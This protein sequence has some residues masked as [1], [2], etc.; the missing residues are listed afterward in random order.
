MRIM[1]GHEVVRDL[2]VP[3][4]RR[5]KVKEDEFCWELPATPGH[6]FVLKRE[7]DPETEVGITELLEQIRDDEEADEPDRADARSLLRQ[8]SQGDTP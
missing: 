6:W 5:P 1:G 4:G 3:D 2:H 8:R 7:C